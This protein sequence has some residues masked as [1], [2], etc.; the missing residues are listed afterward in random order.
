MIR[1]GDGAHLVGHQAMRV[2]L[3]VLTDAATIRYLHQLGHVLI[4]EVSRSSD[5][6]L[7]GWEGGYCD[8]SEEEQSLGNHCSRLVCA[9]QK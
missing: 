9:E 8:C 6:G 2:A 4:F 7:S 1:L 3:W 5:D